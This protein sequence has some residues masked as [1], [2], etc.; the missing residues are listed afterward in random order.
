MAPTA[1]PAPTMPSNMDRPTINRFLLM[2]RKNIPAILYAG[3]FFF[4]AC[5]PADPLALATDLFD[6]GEWEL[7]RRECRRA[8]LADTPPIERFR[9]LHAMSA[10]RS[11]MGAPEAA[12][13]FEAIITA[14]SDLQ[15]TSIA[16]Y[17][18]GRLQW[19]LDQSEKA[20]KS[21]FFAFNNT[22]NKA[23]FLRSSCSLFLL[24]KEHPELKNG[25]ESLIS[26]INTSRD[27]W[28][29]DLFKECA[30]PDPAKTKPSAPNWVIRFYRSQVSPAIGDR[31]TLEPSCSEYFH[32]AS[33]KHGF[34][35]IPMIADRFFR[36]PEVSNQK[37]DPVIMKNGE[38]RYRDPVENHDFWMKK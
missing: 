26:Q 38:I 3:M 22:T 23:L 15:V 16:S 27:Q 10:V 17:E 1:L 13:L 9:L 24:F 7:C 36:E 35:S 28:Y 34:K 29:G 6:K 33:C 11:G 25:N 4:C 12:L 14:G 30:K 8:L 2:R 31:C 32:Q 21:F 37:A 18:L 5:C 19:Q 20:L